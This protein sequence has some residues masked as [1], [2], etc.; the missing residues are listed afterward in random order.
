MA[1]PNLDAFIYF[2]VDGKSRRVPGNFDGG[3]TNDKNAVSD[4][5]KFKWPS[6]LISYRFGF[7]VDPDW[8]ENDK[9]PDGDP[10]MQHRP[11]LNPLT[12]TKVFDTASPGLLEAVDR[13]TVFDS[14][15]L[16]HRRAG[17]KPGHQI[18]ISATLEKVVVLSVDWDAGADGSLVETVQLDFCAITVD[19][20][21]QSS[22][23]GDD[24]ENKVSGSS[25][26]TFPKSANDRTTGLSRIDEGKLEHWIEEVSKQTRINWEK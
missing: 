2:F 7:A 1:E 17:G 14:V 18:M 4:M 21:P 12:V 20:M 16:V 22:H 24:T 15:K 9:G 26:V 19:Y 10:N 23:G 8:A 3:E 25:S 6:Q 5:G 13:A 11:R